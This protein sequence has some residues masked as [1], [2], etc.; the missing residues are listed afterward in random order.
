MPVILNRAVEQQWLSR[1]GAEVSNYCE[2]YNLILFDEMGIYPH[3]HQA[4][5]KIQNAKI[6]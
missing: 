1:D 3:T 2:F 6:L 4:N 5:S